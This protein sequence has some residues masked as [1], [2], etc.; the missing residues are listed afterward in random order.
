MSSLIFLADVV[1]KVG[2]IGMLLPLARTINYKFT[3]KQG[4]NIF[5]VKNEAQGGT[6]VQS[7]EWEGGASPFQPGN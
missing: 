5:S 6:A 2:I 1:T 4:R 3:S 7:G